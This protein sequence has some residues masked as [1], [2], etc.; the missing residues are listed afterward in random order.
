M[1]MQPKIDAAGERATN[2]AASLLALAGVD[3]A[4]RK[5]AECDGKGDA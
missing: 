2:L 3:A 4:L 1:N 5:T